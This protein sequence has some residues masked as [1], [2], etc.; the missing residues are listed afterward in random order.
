MGV[1]GADWRVNLDVF[2]ERRLVALVPG[3]THGVAFLARG[4]S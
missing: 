3:L 1:C 4:C 2:V